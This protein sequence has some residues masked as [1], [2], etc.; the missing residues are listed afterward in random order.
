M[1]AAGPTKIWNAFTD[2]MAKNYDDLTAKGF[3]ARDIEAL[4]VPELIEC[5]EDWVAANP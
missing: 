4:P 5:M 2:F 3:S 1:Q